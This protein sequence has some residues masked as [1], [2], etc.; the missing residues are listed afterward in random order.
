MSS[1][2][3][4][5]IETTCELLETQGYQV[6]GLNQ[7]IQQ[8]GAPKG[9]LY[10]YFPEGKEQLIAEAVESAAE[11]VARRIRNRLADVE[12]PGEAIRQFI[13]TLAHYVRASEFRSGGPITTAALEA[14]STSERVRQACLDAYRSW[15]EAFQAKLVEGGYDDER[16]ARL[17]TFIVASLEGAIILSRTERSVAPLEQV[18][19]ELGNLIH[20]EK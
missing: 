1:T 12:P 7:I 8:S 4:Q 14:A 17:A 16:A 9:S 15:Q 10:Y 19:E 5:I 18:A 11:V 3:E 6:T 2:R 13:L 20:R